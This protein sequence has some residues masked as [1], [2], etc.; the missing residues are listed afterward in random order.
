MKE[1][2]TYNA[3]C[4]NCEHLTNYIMRS[5]N[6]NS[7]SDEGI[8]RVINSYEEKSYKWDSCEN[9]KLHTRMEIVAFDY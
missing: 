8:L 4:R 3:K 7:M 6:V 9:C 1:R 2:V 5:S